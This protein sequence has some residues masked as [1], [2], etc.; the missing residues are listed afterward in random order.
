T[1][2]RSGATPQKSRNGYGAQ[3]IRNDAV[4]KCGSEL[5][6]DFLG[7]VAS[8]LAPTVRHRKVNGTSMAMQ[9]GSYYQTA[10]FLW[11]K[12]SYCIVG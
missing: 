12:E 1:I 2:F 3:L 6:R 4:G 8:K 9:E 7:E 11:L 5:A 10:G